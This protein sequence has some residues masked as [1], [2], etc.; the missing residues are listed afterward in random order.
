MDMFTVGTIK[1]IFTIEEDSKARNPR[2]LSNTSNESFEIVTIESIRAAVIPPI[3][4]DV[5]L[6]LQGGRIETDFSFSILSQ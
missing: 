2:V 4:A 6:M 1:V 5:L 3:P